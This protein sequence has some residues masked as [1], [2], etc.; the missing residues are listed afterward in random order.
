MR[1]LALVLLAALSA[2]GIYGGFALLLSPDGAFLQLPPGWLEGTPFRS[3]RVPGLV[4]LAVNGALPAVAFALVWRRHP[5]AFLI[6]LLQGVLTSGW[7]GVQ[8]ALLRTFYAPLHAPFWLLGA[9]L[10][11]IGARMS[12]DPFTWWLL[13]SRTVLFALLHVSS[14]LVLQALGTKDAFDTASAWWLAYAAFVN[15]VTLASLTRAREDL[16]SLWRFTAGTWRRDLGWLG[17]LLVVAGPI[18]WLPNRLMATAMW[19]N[20]DAGNALMFKPLPTAGLVA[21]ALVFPLTQALAEIPLYFG[22]VAV[23]LAR[24]VPSALATTIAALFLSVQHAALPLLTDGRFMAWRATMFLPFALLVG[25][26]I[27]RRPTLMPYIVV[28]HGLMDLQLPILTYF[29][30]RVPL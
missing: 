5:R 17:G 29:V 15:I 19:G 13:V 28:V 16:A 30:G 25:F 26:L 8:I 18:A 21:I 24:H 12:G 9:L 3:Y 6:V 27:R 20:P 23:R 10:F 4:L 2:G 22:H 7:I 1:T 11:G 14:F